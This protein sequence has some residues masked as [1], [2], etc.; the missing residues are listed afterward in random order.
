[1]AGLI[2]ENGT[3]I[4]QSRCGGALEQDLPLQNTIAW[5]THANG[6]GSAGDKNDLL[7]SVRVLA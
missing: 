6:Y 4:C 3:E 5:D 1:V 2:C 7:S